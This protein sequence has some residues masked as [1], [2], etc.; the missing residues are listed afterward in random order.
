VAAA[1]TC[2]LLGSAGSAQASPT[3]KTIHYHGRRL[4]VPADWRVFDLA[5]R[6]GTCVRFDRHAVYLGRPGADELCPSQ[7]AGRTEAI[8]VEPLGNS[9]GSPLPSPSVTGADALHGSEARIVDRSHRLVITAT[10]NRDPASISRALGMRSL[11]GARAASTLA[12]PESGLLS[13]GRL[14]A[15]AHLAAAASIPGAVYTGRAFDAC[16]APSGSQM[17][18]WSGAY[19]SVGVYIGGANMACSQANL[20]PGWVARQSAAGWHLIPIY[21]GLQAPANQCGCAA[22]SPSRAATQGR[23][24]AQDAVAQARAIGLGSGNPLYYD[25][26]GYA[27]GRQNSSAV[28]SFLGAWTAELHADGYRSGVYSSDDSGIQDL[29]AGYGT[30]Y[31]EPDEIWPASW[32]GQA[33]TTDA[34]IPSPDWANHQRIHQFAGNQ[35]ETHGGVTLNIDVDYVDAATAAA[36]SAGAVQPPASTAPPAIGGSPVPGQTLTEAHGS[37][38]GDPTSFSDAWERCDSQGANCTQVAG[39]TG[40]SYPVGSADL[41]HTLRVLETAT[42]AAG[43]SPVAT[44]A[45]TG[46]VRLPG[47]FWLFTAYGNVFTSAGAP[48]YGSPAAAHSGATFLAGMAPTADLLGY[49]LTDS[50]GQVLPYG[51]APALAMTPALAL[52]HPIIGIVAAPTGGYWLYTAYGNVYTSSGATWYGS[53]AGRSGNRLITGMASTPDGKGYWLVDSSGQVYPYGDAGSLTVRPAPPTAHPIE[54][55]VA[56]PGGGYWLYTA[57]GNI[58]TSSGAT[59]YGSPRASGA[60]ESSIAGMAAT[61]D[62]RGYRLVDSSGRMFAYG[63]APQ[64]SVGLPSAR[65]PITGIVG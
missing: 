52:S 46:V 30:G 9:A 4:M 2:L 60:G 56:S 3:L 53:P 19:R 36:G 33:T 43:T 40:Q 1:L 31:P 13:P 17:T 63:D 38:S 20:T 35:N 65:P 55:I 6:P 47:V 58:Y 37:W 41:G 45:A 15:G 42:N 14:S 62:G 12:P 7:A 50:S 61:P 10:W 25:M 44:S 18:A 21:V 11:A 29:V 59:W 57:Y 49:W 26:E 23:A 28:L 8:L 51:D 54:G 5:S 32:N 24:A 64:L 48:W 22:I 39:A 27:P 16:S 34:N